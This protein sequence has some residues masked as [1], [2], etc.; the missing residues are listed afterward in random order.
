MSEFKCPKCAAPPHKHGKGGAE[1]CHDRHGGDDCEGLLCECED[2]PRSEED[3]HGT[4]FSNPCHNAVCYHCSFVGTV[5]VKPKGLA[6]W[7]KKALDEGWTPPE[8]R[9]RELEG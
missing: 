6:P 8:A 1:K 2:D 7:E 9:R 5:P 3:D 4:S